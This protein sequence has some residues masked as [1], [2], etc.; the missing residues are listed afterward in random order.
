MGHIL[1]SEK[2]L[3]DA[4]KVL[5]MWVTQFVKCVY[6]LSFYKTL[7]VVRQKIRSTNNRLGNA[8]RPH[9]DIIKTLLGT[10]KL[11]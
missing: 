4:L 5:K 7:N 8:Y 6:V 1:I 10:L 2:A 9:I 3:S 11:L